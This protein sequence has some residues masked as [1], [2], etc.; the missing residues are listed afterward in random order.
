M[1]EEILY[2]SKKLSEFKDAAVETF[3]AKADTLSFERRQTL[4]TCVKLFPTMAL[5]A[6]G[7][8]AGGLVGYELSPVL[9]PFDPDVSAAKARIMCTL[10]FSIYGGIAGNLSSILPA[11]DLHYRVS[12]RLKLEPTF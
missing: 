12:K 2:I 9:A 1:E 7:L 8:L 10:A 4:A 3:Y 11:H 5:T 6:G